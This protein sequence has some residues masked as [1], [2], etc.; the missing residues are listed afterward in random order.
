MSE[1]VRADRWLWATRFYKTRAL[2]AQGCE[3]G[4]IKRG[5]HPLKPA[6]QL[7][8]GDILEVPFYEGP[9]TRIVKVAGLIQQRVSAPLAQACY[10]EST[11]PEVIEANRL[12]VKEK[13]DRRVEGD[14]G[15]P[16]KRDRREIER[17][18]DFFG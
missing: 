1:G 15:R 12:A 14:Q 11:S 8:L 5:G 10:I 6:T 7:H 16:T 3:A 9:G 17:F 4:R 13:H 18:R 2:A